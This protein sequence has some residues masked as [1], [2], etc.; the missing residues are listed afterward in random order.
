MEVVVTSVEVMT[1]A[2]AISKLLGK[3]EAKAVTK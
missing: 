1:S 2:V 3:T